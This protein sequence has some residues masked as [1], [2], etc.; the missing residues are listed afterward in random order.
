ME[1]QDDLAILSSARALLPPP[2]ASCC[3]ATGCQIIVED[4]GAV[5]CAAHAGEASLQLQLPLALS[6]R[7][8][9]MHDALLK[10]QT[11][12]DRAY[13][14]LSPRAEAQ[15]SPEDPAVSERVA[16]LEQEASSFREECSKLALELDS[17]RLQGEAAGL[18]LGVLRD[19]ERALA[20]AESA[21]ANEAAALR[22]ALTLAHRE[23]QELRGRL[24]AAPSEE[25]RT[26]L[27]VLA[28]LA[29]RAPAR[30]QV[31]EAPAAPSATSVSDSAT[32]AGEAR[33]ATSLRSAEAARV[34][35]ELARLSELR[36][37]LDA[38]T[39]S[40]HARGRPGPGTSG[41][42][43]QR[44][45]RSYTGELLIECGSAETGMG[46]GAAVEAGGSSEGGGLWASA[47]GPCYS[48]D[49]ASSAS[50]P[51]FTLRLG[52]SPLAKQVAA[53]LASGGQAPVVL[54]GTPDGKRVAMGGA[55][56]EGPG[57]ALEFAPEG[58]T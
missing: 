49:V 35:S 39:A 30:A 21:A 56:H 5:T 31:V 34:G 46:A 57:R 8:L 36:G 17:A 2:F 11:L 23:V 18:A 27:A 7:L 53:A 26:H 58:A 37:R 15:S 6:L 52:N 1:D 13:A 16:K 12:A 28:P 38:M 4:A 14:Q 41:G 29:A 3:W 25:R 44:S 40:V 19:S 50:R 33:A 42:T 22:A 9:A 24:E 51:R 54:R 55:A 10:E 48:A 43:P 45:G 20:V 32:A 47:G